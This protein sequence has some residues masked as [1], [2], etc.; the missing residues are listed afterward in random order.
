MASR[1]G[2]RG[3]Q[4][5]LIGYQYLPGRDSAGWPNYNSDG[6]GEWVY[7]TKLDGPYRKAPIMIDK[8]QAT[9]RFPRLRGSAAR[10]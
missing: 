3:G 2:I 6:L 10:E 1:R 4:G 5:N 7:R 8:I 9:G